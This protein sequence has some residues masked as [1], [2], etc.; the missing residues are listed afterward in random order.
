[1]G[2]SNKTRDLDHPEKT[3]AYSLVL[4]EKSNLI[5][6]YEKIA[7]TTNPR[8]TFNGFS[9]YPLFWSYIL[10]G[11]DGLCRADY[12]ILKIDSIRHG[13]AGSSLQVQISTFHPD[14]VRDP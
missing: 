6:R 3:G 2:S 9:N 1:M 13:W 8:F 14:I 11:H 7:P 5:G 12:L 4:S 10:I